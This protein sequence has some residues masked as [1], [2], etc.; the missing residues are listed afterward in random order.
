MRELTTRSLEA[1]PSGT[2]L[3]RFMRCLVQG[4]DL[5][6]ARQIA[7]QAAWPDT[8]Q[9]RKTFDDL[10]TKGAIAPGTSTDAAWAS[11]LV[12]SRLA[13]EAIE[14]MRGPSIVEQLA[15]AARRVPFGMRVPLDATSAL[16]GDWIPE[17]APTP[18]VAL[19]F[20]TVPALD[21]TKLGAIVPFTRE[22]VVAGEPT[23]EATVRNSLLGTLARTIDQIFLDPARAAA[24]DRPASITNGAPTVTS[25]GTTAAAIGADLAAMRALITTAGGGLTWIMRKKTMST[26]AGA[27]G[28]SVSGL[29]GSLSG[30]PIVVS[31]NSPAQITLADMAAII[32]ADDGAF[33]V[34]KSVEST[35]QLNTTPDAPATAATVYVP[36]LQ[37]NLVAFKA[38]R[39]I[40]WARVV[41]GAVVYM[42][43]A[44]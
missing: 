2:S 13:A 42:P 22:L 5:Y 34:S 41:S 24:P 16:I 14:L 43:V 21:A 9:V 19:S 23:A 1:L 40:N 15:G 28:A 26:I 12:E 36:L 25:T 8:P 32:Y 37:H 20:T 3:N 29:P 4:H 7:H 30:L 31:D 6:E 38:L 17:G 44:Y 39:W 11:A 10:L 27:L 35:I 18:A 33:A